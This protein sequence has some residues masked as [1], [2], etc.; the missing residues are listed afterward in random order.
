[1]NSGTFTNHSAYS[2]TKNSTKHLLIP[3]MVVD[4]F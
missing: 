2:I 1:M 4:D 3:A